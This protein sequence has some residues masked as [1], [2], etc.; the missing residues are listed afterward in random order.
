MTT[1]KNWVHSAQTKRKNKGKNT[2]G[3]VDGTVLSA[4]HD[5]DEKP[6]HYR[7]LEDLP[8]DWNRDRNYDQSGKENSRELGSGERNDRVVREVRE[9]DEAPGAGRLEF[10]AK[11]PQTH[12]KDSGNEMEQPEDHCAGQ[13]DGVSDKEPCNEDYVGQCYGVH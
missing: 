4:Y 9:F 13:H 8:A 5:T 2:T 7:H 1:I 3:G 11:I 6:T 12:M 10:H